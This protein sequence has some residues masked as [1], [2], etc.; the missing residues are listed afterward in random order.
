[1]KNKAASLSF[2][3]VLME[4][5]KEMVFVVKVDKGC[6]FTYE[7][8]NS[9]VIESTLLD[10]TS[11][12]KTFDDIHS[13][14]MAQFLNGKYGEVVQKNQ[15][16]SYED[17]F[18]STAKNLFYSKTILTPLFDNAGKCTH[19]VSL[20]K[21]ITNEKIA[22]LESEGIRERLEESSARYRS[23]FDSN[24]DAIF[25]VDFKGCITG[26]NSAGH[27]LSGYFINE[28]ASKSFIEF[29][30]PA[31]KEQAKAHFH[32]SILGNIK[33]CRLQ[34]SNKSGASVA[35]LVKFIPIN[36]KSKITGFY[37]IAKDM[38]ELDKIASLYEAGEENFR[39]IAEHVHDVIILMDHHKNFLYVSPSSENIFGFKADQVTAQKPIYSVHPE[40]IVTIS[41]AFEQAAKDASSYLVQIRLLHQER[42]WIWAEIN[43][44]SVFGEDK[45]FNHMVMVARDIS[46]QKEY[47]SQ[48]KHF[49][50]FDS[51]TELPNRRYFQEYATERLELKEKN[52]S[53]IAVLI[54]DIDD[55]K[56]INDQW[57]H[58]TGDAVIQ[59]FGYRLNSCMHGENMA[60]RLG[61]DEFVILLADID[62]KE[63]VAE[64]A[65]SIYRVMK[66]PIKVLGLSLEISISMGIALAPAE[67]I[68][69]S[70]M[71]KR[72][73]TA[74][75][76]AKQQEK[77]TFQV[78]PT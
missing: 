51:L 10:A 54:L 75:Y 69:I 21:D 9:A 32:F 36:V 78:S 40:D 18:Y 35:C 67:K 56:E 30:V 22:K 59:E 71:M 28:L 68:S 31:E 8:F 7:F 65:D 50:Y 61:G 2:A 58:E 52:Q 55:F 42:G 48:L 20:V 6:S 38:T 4:G 45:S 73:D 49:A 1:M 62:T 24:A 64:V 34:I 11:I 46:I 37:M 60:A 19:I 76:K 77:N 66:E 16:M 3:R 15:S 63:Q 33:D 39:I 57:G 74:M 12:G 70:A 25:T 27:K 41:S 5:I 29:V 14:I 17:S 47:E 26:G 53:G 44:T 72:A 23:L 43:G 13:T